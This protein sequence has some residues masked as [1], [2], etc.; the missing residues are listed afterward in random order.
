MTL[1]QDHVYN[2]SPEDS[3]P[4]TNMFSSFADDE[5]TKESLFPDQDNENE[6]DTDKST[7]TGKKSGSA[8][9]KGPGAADK[10]ATHNAIE[11]ARRE[12]L[13]G[14]FMTLAEAL[15][16]M[17]HVKRP[18]K[19]IIVNKALD[20]VFEAQVKEHALIKEN[21]E[22]RRQVD[23]LRARL[24]MAPLP[25]PT[26][27]PTSGAR[28]MATTTIKQDSPAEIARQCP[29]QLALKALEAQSVYAGQTSPSDHSPQA[30]PS[31]PATI[32]L[33]PSA[34]N[35]ALQTGPVLFPHAESVSSDGEGPMQ[36]SQSSFGPGTP[37]LSTNSPSP[38][39]PTSG[40]QQ[41]NM[42]AAMT[43]SGGYLAQ[44]QAL[45]G[46]FGYPTNG[47]HM[48]A[49][50]LSQQHA[51]LIAAHFQQHAQQLGSHNASHTPYSMG[52]SFL[53]LGVGSNY[54]GG[55]AGMPFGWNSSYGIAV[56]GVDGRPHMDSYGF[57]S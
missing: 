21:N 16:A 9:R 29:P 52:D 46:T 8:C 6:L 26:P 28:H 18:S 37:P 17:A 49:P 33:S 54:G 38:Y 41:L 2:F 27:L 45:A 48:N 22:L 24:G 36:G 35:Y 34:S 1:A 31:P 19:S 50:L 42:T 20:F 39:I 30:L 32:D 40:A 15:P 47:M 43:N 5:D 10:R 51:A 12:S 11:R 14:R 44:A 13:N 7:L 3:S 56:G 23:Q 4:D 53:G 25:P 57:T 55:S